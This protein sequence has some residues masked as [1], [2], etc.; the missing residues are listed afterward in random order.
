MV[1]VHYFF[2]P[3]CGWCYGATSLL[4]VMAANSE[5][6]LEFH[7]GGM[8]D[9]KAISPS[10]R[11]HILEHDERIAKLTGAAFGEDY[12]QRVQ[13]N[14]EM[15]LDSFI[16]ARAILTA[17][18]L[19]LPPLDMLEA[20]QRAHYFEG[21]LVNHPEVLKE[22]SV[23]LGIDGEQWHNAM[24]ANEGIE[25]KAISESQQLMQRL[26]VHGYP[27]LIL[28]VNNQLIKLP[29]TDFYGKPDEWRQLV[30]RYIGSNSSNFQ[31]NM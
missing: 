23:N 1:T 24:T 25:Q 10:F 3:M 6:K 28:E 22:L 29:H 2:D 30:D 27:T 16:T 4:A 20:I 19:G 13:S 7:P 5:I 15:V 18:Q 21:K 11:R 26:Q 31:A 9:N 8:I 12:I 14:D 17:E